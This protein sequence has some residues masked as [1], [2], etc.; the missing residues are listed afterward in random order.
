MLHSPNHMSIQYMTPAA[1]ELVL[2]KLKTTFWTT[3]KYQQEIDNV[4]RFIKNGAGSDGAEFC[5]Q[6]K[7]TDAY[8]KQNF[9][10]THPEI[11]RAM[12]YE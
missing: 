12:G 8:R 1:Q 7:Q 6:M 3:H 2:S 10:D 11:A 5:R 9:M 4:I